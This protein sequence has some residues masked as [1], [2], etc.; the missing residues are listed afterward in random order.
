VRILIIGAGDVGFHL[1][2][3]LSEEHHD[4][5]VIEQDRERVRVIED[6]MDAL[7][8]EGNGASLTSSSRRASSAPTCSSP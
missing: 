2:R 3:Q 5:V 7:V 6:S 4:V 1:A 8:I